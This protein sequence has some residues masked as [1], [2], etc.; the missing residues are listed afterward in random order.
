[1]R[2]GSIDLS[3]SVYIPGEGSLKPNGK[4][5]SLELFSDDLSESS[6]E[7]ELQGSLSGN[8][9]GTLQEAGSDISETL[10]SGVA[11]CRTFEVDPDINIRFKCG[12]ATGTV[13]YV[14]I[15]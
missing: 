14:I 15:E 13:E 9:W 7:V 3:E 5:V 8:R 6:I 10:T 4:L 2:T 1:M 12:T 11:L